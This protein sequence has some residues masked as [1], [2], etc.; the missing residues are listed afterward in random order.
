MIMI[1][2]LVIF[3][4]IFFGCYFWLSIFG[5][6]SMVVYIWLFSLHRIL[7][8][9]CLSGFGDTSVLVPLVLVTIGLM[10]L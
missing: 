6:L 8:I 2:I 7:N 1:V 9:P 4:Y 10:S 3:S 5:C